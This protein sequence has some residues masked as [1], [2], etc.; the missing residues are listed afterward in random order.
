MIEKEEEIAGRGRHDCRPDSKEMKDEDKTKEQL[1]AELEDL[2]G[3][4][5]EM[6]ARQSESLMKA[7]YALA[8]SERKYRALVEGSSDAILMVDKER[9]I[10]S[11]NR[12]F[13]D[14]FGLE[15]EEVEGRTTRLI[16][17]SEESYLNF[18]K[19]VFGEVEARGSFMV[20][21]SLMKKDGTILPIEET[22]SVVRDDQG[23]TK[24]YVAIIRDISK[25]KEAQEEL[26]LYRERLEEMV[27]ERTRELEEAHKALLQKEKLKTLGAISAE[28]AH[29]IRNPL[30]S[31]GGFAR[32]L[33]KRFPDATE[34]DIILE[35]SRRLEKILDRI[36]NYL[37][38][39]EMR[40]QECSVNAIVSETL[41]FLIPE[42]RREGVSTKLDLEQD[43][44]AA[45]ADPGIL[46]Q[47]FINVIRSAMRLMDKKE[48][49]VI[50]AFE[51]DQSIQ[52]HFESLIQS[53]KKISRD[54]T[55]F[56]AQDEHG[57][58]VAGPLCS[59][60]L[61]DMGG[62]LSFSQE[63][64]YMTFTVSLPKAFQ[65]GMA[66]DGSGI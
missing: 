31:I 30:M 65:P 50:K 38:P 33:Q 34:V 2:R 5:A 48:A 40:P 21:W 60:L 7:Q 46:T 26:K 66:I 44:P 10:V 57:G 56:I 12:A 25:R 19:K 3:Q 55:P 13:L 45:Y 1:I 32:R 6:G 35:E 64:N 29:E 47:V 14:L 15:R 18:G 37:K 17:P 16:H 11:F 61:Q 54:E 43:M 20:E 42:L 49:L 36:R 24:A 53:Q 4:M 63:K 51:T 8:E 52:V 9:R 62:V 58:N 28:V 59:R 41:D 39:V 23:A 27:M 22:L